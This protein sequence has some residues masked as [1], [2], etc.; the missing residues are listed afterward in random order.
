MTFEGTFFGRVTLSRWLLGLG[1]QRGARLAQAR[2]NS[3]NNDYNCGD[4]ADDD[5]LDVRVDVGPV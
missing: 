5:N 4:Q 1:I 2:L 3:D